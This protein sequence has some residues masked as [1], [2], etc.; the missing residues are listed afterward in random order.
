MISG[1][2]KLYQI[3]REKEQAKHDVVGFVETLDF[4]V[5]LNAET[6]YLSAEMTL[7]NEVN[8]R[9]NCSRVSVGWLK[10]GYIRVQAISHME[11]FEKKMDAVQ[12]LEA[13][14]EES[15]D[16]DEE[17][18][19]PKGSGRYTITKDHERFALSQGVPYMLS[20]PIRQDGEPAGVLT[21]ERE[22]E[23]FVQKDINALRLI[24]DQASQRLA[25]LKR[26]DQWIGA[27]LV[28]AARKGLGKLFGIEH[29]FIKLLGLAIFALIAFAVF[30]NWA[31]RV[32]A[33]FILKTDDLAYI[34]APFDGYIQN[35]HIQVG[36]SV[37][38][39]ELL[40]TLD[41]RELLLEESS[42]N[43]DR[44]RY[45]R[46][47]KKSGARDDLAEMRIAEALKVQSEAKLDLIRYH[48]SNS[49]LR[50]P[51]SGIIVEGELK[52]L[53]GAPVRKGDVLFK[54]AK[55]E[56]IYAVLDVDE[57]DIHEVTLQQSGEV[58]FISRPELK[59]PIEVQLIEPVAV[60]KE[61]GNVFQI[62]C[63]FKNGVENWW[64]PGM[65]GIAKINA[66]KRNILWILTHRTID[67]F[68][69][70]LWW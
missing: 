19:I 50:A 39:G 37:D 29:T 33:P 70:L 49:E 60:T 17:I 2:P 67:F 4:M 43:A 55:I 46:E 42:A 52:E 59:F 7:C 12:S 20:L 9:F 21:C 64:R 23:P 25:D 35:V 18:V 10:R 28:D 13:A 63:G 68:R 32:E 27:T 47:A 34:P 6:R 48:L 62:R 61:K 16:Q 56:K 53:L 22:N 1:V 26:S 11:R 30:G 38:K 54:V 31:Y 40:L 45:A 66:G 57:K 14:M 24:C 69:L 15:F 65:S 58:A 51:F 41:D 3:R 36:D 44:T 8:S 5:L